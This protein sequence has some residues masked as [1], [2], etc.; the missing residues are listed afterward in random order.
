MADAGKQKSANKLDNFA[1][2]LDAM[3]DN[4]ASSSAQQIGLIDDDDAIDRMLMGDSFTHTELV[5]EVDEFADIDALIS[6]DL[7]NQRQ[8]V[9]LIDEFDTPEPEAQI[10][11]V[12][13]FPDQQ[14]EEI[15]EFADNDE[16]AEI[17]EL[18]P[19]QDLAEQQPSEPD[20]VE[21]LI[22]GDDFFAVDEEN[23]PLPESLSSQM[24]DIEN[25]A[26]IDEFSEPPSKVD[27]NNADFLMADFDISADDEFA[28]DAETVFTPPK[29]EP[30]VA[31]AEMVAAPIVEY[32]DLDTELAVDEPIG[33]VTETPQII[34]PAIDHSAELA[35]IAAQITGLK[36]QQVNLKQEIT[37]R[38]GKEELANSL[39]PLGG[40][41][42]EIKKTKRTV[43]AL[44]QQ[45]PVA[46][47]AANVVAVI[48]LMTGLGLGF[49]G[50]IAK[51]Q[52]VELSAIIGKMQEQI[53]QAPAGQA[54]DYALLRK[55]LDALTVADSVTAAQIAEL[56]KG[57][58]SDN[59]A[60]ATAT[61]SGGGDLAAKVA[62]LSNQNMQIGAELETL[63]NKVSVLEK[64]RVAVVAA[65]KEK[66]EP[67]KPPVVVENW[68][69]NLI[70]FKQDWYAKRK[71]EEFAAKGVPAKV[72]KTESKGEV[73]YR[74]SVDGFKSQYEAAAYAAKVKKSLNLDSVWLTRNKD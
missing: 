2:E 10:A 30:V 46:A 17:A 1:D 54:A 7:G 71:A 62:D 73:W 65:P 21:K 52:V 24:V 58:Q 47:Y 22:A 53:N 18:E 44:S 49:Q 41:E 25:M 63:Q 32:V 72:T 19:I 9:E 50:Y 48:A 57:L 20:A 8:V 45:K 39:E 51:S 74:L 4:E 42:T 16:F 23:L 67:K 66:P 64:T 56:S 35:A 68:A 43:E 36:K 15:D 33:K 26:E 14:V 12:T 59:T 11:A 34:T 5:D 3:L 28:E 55:E 61:K 13:D 70:A 31:A 69:V 6:A 40:L 38:V 27:A 29:P 37:E 60:A